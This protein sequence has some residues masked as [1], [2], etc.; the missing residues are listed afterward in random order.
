MAKSDQ[1]LAVF[2]ACL[3]SRSLGLDFGQS[4]VILEGQRQIKSKIE[5]VF[6]VTGEIRAGTEPVR[7]GQHLAR[8]DCPLDVP[9]DIVQP[10]ASGDI[11]DTLQI[12]RSL[13]PAGF[14]EIAQQF[15]KFIAK[16]RAGDTAA[17]LVRL[18]QPP[19]RYDVIFGCRLV[20]EAVD[21]LEGTGDDIESVTPF[22]GSEPLG[23]DA[24]RLLL[25]RRFDV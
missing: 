14:D 8:T 6:S 4:A 5:G 19:Y 21:G 22:V 3:C 16:L 12:R 23:K 24:Y 25:C 2:K 13:A 20:P 18:R 15:V 1:R 10:C 9:R 11:G 17:L 7:N